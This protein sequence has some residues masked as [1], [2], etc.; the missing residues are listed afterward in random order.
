MA[1]GT[2]YG[3]QG[4]N[5]WKSLIAAKY[6]GLELAFKESQVGVD[7]K[8]PEFLKKWPLGK[9]PTFEDSEGFY[10]NE[11]DAIAYY[12]MCLLL[13]PLARVP[14]IIRVPLVHII[15]HNSPHS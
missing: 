9:V 13:S 12:G 15:D 5:T 10:L 7:T 6:N 1:I 11:S 2:I 3:Y 14:Y 8:K 4:S